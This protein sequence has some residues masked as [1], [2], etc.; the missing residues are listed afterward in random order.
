MTLR[1]LQA[2]AHRIAQEHGFWDAPRE[3]GTLLALVHSEISEALEAD[4]HGDRGGLAHELADAVIRIVDL[5]AGL[6]FD[7]QSF[8]ET[9]M[10]EN[11]TRPR[12]HGKAY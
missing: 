4:R 6:E 3:T 1:K 12:K 10:K 5:A 7:L 11:E 2:E 8:V 9:A